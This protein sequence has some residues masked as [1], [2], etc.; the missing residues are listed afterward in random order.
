MNNKSCIDNGHQYGLWHIEK[1]QNIAWRSCNKCRFRRELPATDEIY[2]EI[3][4]QDEALKIFR[5]FQIVDNND[6]NII[7]YLNLIIEDYMHYLDR[8][9]LIALT[10]R[11]KELEQLDIINLQDAFYNINLDGFWCLNGDNKENYNYIEIDDNNTI[12]ETST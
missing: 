11:I 3:K 5:A 12:I 10:S 6:E 9:S 8:K 4:K 2:G 7:N 1:E